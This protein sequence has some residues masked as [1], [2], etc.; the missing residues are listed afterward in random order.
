MLQNCFFKVEVE[1][2]VEVERAWEQGRGRERGRKT[3]S[4]RLCIVNTQ[5]N[6]GL[7]FMNREI[8]PEPKSRVGRLTD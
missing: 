8:M 2:R 5:P 3:I 7:E 6:A 1:S 4:S